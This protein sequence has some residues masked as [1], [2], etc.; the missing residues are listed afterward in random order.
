MSCNN[1]KYL[2]IFVISSN[3]QNKPYKYYCLKNK[4]TSF[5]SKFI[6]G[7]SYLSQEKVY[8]TEEQFEFFNKKF[9]ICFEKNDFTKI[10]FWRLFLSI[11]AIV[12]SSFSLYKNFKQN[13]SI[14]S[15]NDNLETIVNSKVDSII[16]NNNILIEKKNTTPKPPPSKIKTKK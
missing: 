4:F 6:L 3:P 12:I 11:L 1:C 15:I 10:E 7:S 5:D 2:R 8:Y 16:K 14:K 9:R 13:N